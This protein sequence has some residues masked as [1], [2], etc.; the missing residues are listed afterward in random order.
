[1]SEKQK[2]YE[3]KYKE[4]IKA[5]WDKLKQSLMNDQ[6]RAFR[7]YYFTMHPYEQA[8]FF[9]E[10]EGELRFRLYGYVSPDEFAEIIESMD[11]EET[12]PYFT[13]MDPRYSAAIFSALPADDAVDILNMLDKEEVVSFLTRMDKES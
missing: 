6:M 2:Q 7:K 9:Q 1:M 5:D 12:L 13:E 11:I 4:N 8:T 10:L 3:E